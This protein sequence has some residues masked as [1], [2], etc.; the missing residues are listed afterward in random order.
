MA[1]VIKTELICSQLSFLLFRIVATDSGLKTYMTNVNCNTLL[2]RTIPQTHFLLRIGRNYS[3]CRR[4]GGVLNSPRFSFFLF[5]S[6]SQVGAALM[7]D[8]AGHKPRE[9]T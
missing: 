7:G 2:N 4:Q 3:A 1:I 6:V 9:P 8:T 5:F